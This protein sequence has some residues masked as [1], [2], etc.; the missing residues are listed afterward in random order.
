MVKAP[1]SK[2]VLPSINPSY[3]QDPADAAVRHLRAAYADL[4]RQPLPS[5]LTALI[6]NFPRS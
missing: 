4:L 3:E 1:A 6:E 2:L 5:R